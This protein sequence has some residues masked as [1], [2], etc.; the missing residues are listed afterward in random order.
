MGLVSYYVTSPK[1]CF[2]TEDYNE[3]MNEHYHKSDEDDDEKRI[4]KWF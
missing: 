1:M 2:S 3:R 4:F